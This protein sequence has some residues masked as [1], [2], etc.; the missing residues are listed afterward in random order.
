[1]GLYMH[2]SHIEDTEFRDGRCSVEGVIRYE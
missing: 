1:M 2:T